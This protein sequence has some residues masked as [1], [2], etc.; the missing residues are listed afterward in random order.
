MSV[1]YMATV[2][3][4]AMTFHI[5]ARGG[6]TDNCL[7]PPTESR[8]NKEFLAP[9]SGD[10]DPLKNMSAEKRLLNTLMT[11]YQRVGRPGRP[12]LNITTAT[13]VVFALGLIQMDLDE[14]HNILT[15]SMWTR[16]LIGLRQRPDLLCLR[17]IHIAAELSTIRSPPRLLTLAENEKVLLSSQKSFRDF[18]ICLLPLSIVLQQWRDEYLTWLPDQYDGI[19]AIRI[20]PNLIWIPDITLYNTADAEVPARSA[21]AVISSD[22]VVTWYP[23]AIFKSSCSI[24]V[25]H[26]PFDRQRCHM[27]F[28]S[29]THT[30]REI[31]LRM[32][33]DQ[34]I[35]LS[36]FKSD[37]K[38]SS[39]WDIVNVSAARRLMPS[40]DHEP[41]Y[42]VLM[43]EL[44]LKRKVVFS[45]YILTLPCVF[46]AFLT[47]VVF[48]LPPDRPDRTGLAMSTF[49]SFMLMLLILVEAAPPAT[50][51][52]P[53][54]GVYYCFNMVIIMLSIILSSMV[55]NISRGSRSHVPHYLR[56][57]VLD[58]MGKVLYR[59]QHSTSCHSTSKECD[60]EAV[61]M[62][63]M[64][65]DDELHCS[66]ST[67][68]PSAR[69]PEKEIYNDDNMADGALSLLRRL[70]QKVFEI[71]R[72]MQKVDTRTDDDRSRSQYKYDIR[73]DWRRVAKILDRLF[74]I[75]YILLI[76][77]SLLTLFPKPS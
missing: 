22:G 25:T 33:Y 48:W 66:S 8:V 24:D 32:D 31:D 12:V 60:S 46:L 27:W 77:A 68:T 7:T 69:N 37:F 2:L 23:H 67:T 57:I 6:Q 44:L 53:T 72:I 42:V 71:R 54:L 39:A 41:N 11:N 15:M 56:V 17:M 21:L 58:W 49:S 20:E 76:L 30:S 4:A 19:E 61:D 55:V 74:F 47:V 34:G 10:L 45:S 28:G 13:H 26:F 73:D 9:P 70:D 75:V 52:I 3:M 43:L 59:E 35:D 51:S 14:K 64:P 18:S 50:S 63:R 38:E 16:L 36:T 29:W 62:L 5:R 40:A 1:R 65:F